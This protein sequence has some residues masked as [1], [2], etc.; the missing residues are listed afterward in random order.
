[1]SAMKQ[2]NDSEI[3]NQRECIKKN[4]WKNY[5]EEIFTKTLSGKKLKHLTGKLSA[6]GFSVQGWKLLIFNQTKQ[7]K[8]RNILQFCYNR[9]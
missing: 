8:F 2:V 3:I 6:D 9:V 5:L 7:E 1:M 4:H